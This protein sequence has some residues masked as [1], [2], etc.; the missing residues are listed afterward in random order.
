MTRALHPSRSSPLL[1]WRWA[2]PWACWW[3]AWW[4]AWW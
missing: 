2:G 3:W 1:L 4:R